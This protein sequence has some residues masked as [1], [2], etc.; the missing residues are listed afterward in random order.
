L[1]KEIKEDDLALAVDYEKTASNP[2]FFDLYQSK[3]S[4]L[5]RLME[6]WELIQEEIDNL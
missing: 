3:K 2:K 1:E 6:E 5:E 4:D